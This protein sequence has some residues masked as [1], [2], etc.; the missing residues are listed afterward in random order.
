MD[1]ITLATPDDW[2]LHLRDGAAMADIVD[3]SARQFGR[4][5]VMPNLKPPVTT[6][7]AALEYRGRILAALPE[8]ARFEPLMALYLTDATPAD[9]IRRAAETPEI[10]GFK[11]YPAGATTHSE[12]GVTGIEKVH[13]ALEALERHGVPLLI[14]GEVTDAEVDIFDRE[15]RFIESV[16]EPL[17]RGFP[18]LR[19][20]LEHV[21]TKEGVEFVQ[22][23]GPRVGATITA[24]HL[25][26]NRNAL[27]AGGIRP[28][29]YCLPVLKR[30]SH[31]RALVA[32]ATSGDAHFFLGTDSA[33]HPRPQ[34]ESACGCAGC[35]TALTA[36]ELYAIAFERAGALHM[37]ERFASHNGADFY[38]RPRNRGT[39]TLHRTPWQIPD[40]LPFGAESLVPA[41]AGEPLAWRASRH[42]G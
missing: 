35:Y 27:L 29:H 11:L 19:I 23:R 10:I 34:K 25:L 38:G 14:H 6:V 17:V 33:P 4:A 32:A 30:E 5:V 37:L 1:S 21:T 22:S 12:A 26:Y 9:E 28:H 16:L 3:H 2:H 15:A 20:V 40:A 41:M 13:R 18:E 39:L 31:R 42:T 7:A 8:N 36:M 24:H